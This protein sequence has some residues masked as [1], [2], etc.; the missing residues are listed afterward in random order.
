LYNC[1]MTYNGEPRDPK[2]FVLIYNRITE[3]VSMNTNECYYS[4]GSVIP[5]SG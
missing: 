1:M 5:I 4:T 2:T 3:T